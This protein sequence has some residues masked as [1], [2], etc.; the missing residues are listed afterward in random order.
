M[1]G[2]QEMPQWRF[3]LV[4]SKVEKSSKCLIVVLEFVNDRVG[5]TSEDIYVFPH[6]IVKLFFVH[7]TVGIMIM[8]NL[9]H[10]TSWYF[11][12]VLLD[13]TIE[14][15]RK[16]PSKSYWLTPDSK[17]CVCTSLNFIFSIVF[18]SCKN[19]DIKFSK[20]LKLKTLCWL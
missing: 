12:Y 14:I 8:T 2:L 5:Y 7:D 9:S 20:A 4:L 11:I 3:G 18:H 15:W 13:V 16:S 6:I 1:L 17:C 19:N 10:D